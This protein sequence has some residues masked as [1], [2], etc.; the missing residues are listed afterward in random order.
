MV[1]FESDMIT[2]NIPMEGVAVE[3]GWMIQ[4]RAHTLPVVR[5]TDDYSTNLLYNV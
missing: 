3:K 5:E 2:L 1:L 4:P